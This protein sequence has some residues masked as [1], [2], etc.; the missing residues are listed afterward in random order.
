MF[1]IP[2]QMQ[3]EFGYPAITQEMKAKIFGLNAARIYGIDVDATRTEIDEDDVTAL[4]T[5]FLLDPNSVSVPDRRKY[6]GP[7]TRREFLRLL[8]RERFV[9]HG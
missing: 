5:A 4:R 3:E 7:R 8:E 1:Q 6:E 9:G 2:E